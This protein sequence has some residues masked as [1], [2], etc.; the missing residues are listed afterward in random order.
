ME[1]R[2]IIAGVRYT[3]LGALAESSQCP[4]WKKRR[5]KRGES[6]TINVHK[7][8]FIKVLIAQTH[9]GYK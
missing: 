5:S 3:V 7:A 6:N 4:G 2:S 9:S 1:V 8:R